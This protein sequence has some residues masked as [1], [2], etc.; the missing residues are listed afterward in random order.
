MDLAGEET[1]FG[2]PEADLLPALE[3]LR[4]REGLR[5]EGLMVLPPYLEDPEKVRPFFRRLRALRTSARAKRGSSRVA[6]SRWE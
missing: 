5:V 6:S 2:L 4:G 1:K 3:A